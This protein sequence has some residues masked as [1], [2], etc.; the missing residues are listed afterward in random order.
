MPLT[1][2]WILDINYEVKNHQPEIW[3]WGIDSEGRRVLIIDKSFTTYFYVLPE[4][5]EDAEKLADRIRKVCANL[6]YITG[7]E[8]VDR[9][10]FGKPVKAIKIYCQDPDIMPEYIKVISKVKGIS[11]FLEDDIRY[12]MRYMIDNNIV[13]CGW[14][15]VEVEECPNVLNVQVDKVLIA[16]STPRY[17][18]E[19]IDIPKLRILGFSMICY[20]PKGSPKPEKNP[21]VI[22]SA[23]TNTGEEKQ[24]IAEKTE[25]DRKIINDFMNFIR[26]FDPDIIVGFETNRRDIPY[27]VARA[28]ANGLSLVIDR[29]GA[30]PHTSTYGHVSITG[31]ANVD[32]F[33]Y[34]DEFPEVKVKTLENIA[35]Y[36]GVMKIEERVLIEDFEYAQYWDDPSK[37]PELLKF[38]MDNTRCIMGITEA[39]LDFAIQ[40]SSLVGLPLDHVG[41][42]AVG[43]RVE[44]FLIR[45]A[46]HMGELVPKKIERAYTPYAG[47]LV[48]E[49]NPGIHENIAVLDFKSMYPNIMIS[50]NVSPDTYIPPGEPEI[51]AFIAPEVNHRFRKEPPG[52]YREVLAKLIKARD[53]VREE[54]KRVDR[55]TIKYRILDARQKAIKVITNA[56]Y[57][58]AGWIGAR[59][60]IKPVAEAVTAWGR[61]IIM[62]TIKAAKNIGLEVIYG[63]TDSIFVRNDPEKIE[64]LSKIIEEKFGL[65][66]KPDK[67]YTRVLFTEAKKRYCG[68]MPDGKLDIVGLEVVRGDWANVAKHIQE[69]VLEIILKEQTVRRA[70][71]YVRKYIINLR[72]KKI[73]YRDLII[74]KTLTKSPEEYEVKAPHVEAAKSLQKEGWTLTVGDKVGYVITVGS[75]KLHERAKPYLLASYDEI[76]IE[77]YVTNQIVPAALR[78]L[79]LFGIKEN[80]LL[81]PKTGKVQTLLEFF[82]KS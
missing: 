7:V 38:L 5:G 66:I 64:R 69:K 70:V 45:H 55:G 29:A 39:I 37:R 56:T 49:P 59:W 65:E 40:L 42:A 21:I 28:K 74:W 9:K 77:Y 76:D 3:L 72:E 33:D 16:K 12:S 44:W 11:S 27:L 61:H 26:N 19:M 75:G 82:G 30:E 41:T 14:H 1:R 63:D 23:I 24:F 43:F 57:G 15:E 6:P 62:S 8:V 13:P 78:I 60:Y 71:D 35:D 52:F 48:L 18:S 51:D 47:A 73:P 58:Y 79:S 54:L 32:L 50:Y 36:L 31:R 17:L 2:F 34:A 10:Y 20:S 22:I 46:Y 25:D 4:E 53:H 81:P 80:D 68:L 67:V